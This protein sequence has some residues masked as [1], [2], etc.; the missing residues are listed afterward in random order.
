M[1]SI[2]T[3]KPVVRK[4]SA[5]AFS[6]ALGGQESSYPVYQFSGVNKYERPH[7][8]YPF[9]APVD[10]RITQES[11]PRITEADDARIIENSGP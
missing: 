5:K 1:A 8:R 2:P 7:G 3:A 10:S 4:I 9:T 6:Y 11:D